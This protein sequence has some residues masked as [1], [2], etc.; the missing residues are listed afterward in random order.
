MW[1]GGQ[2]H[3]ADCLQKEDTYLVHLA[4]HVVDGVP[5]GQGGDLRF[6]KMLQ[7]EMLQVEPLVALPHVYELVPVVEHD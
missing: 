4:V 3:A 6:V 2:G 5:V 1:G 7:E